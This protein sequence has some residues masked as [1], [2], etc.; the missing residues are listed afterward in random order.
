MEPPRF[1]YRERYERRRR[2]QTSS[3]RARVIA[4]LVGVALIGA[5]VFVLR[6]VFTPGDQPPASVSVPSQPTAT[7]GAPAD[8]AISTVGP[9]TAITSGQVPPKPPVA[10][11]TQATPVSHPSPSGYRRVEDITQW[12][13]LNKVR[14]SVSGS[15]VQ[16]LGPLGRAYAFV[17]NG[18]AP[19]SPQPAPSLLVSYDGPPDP[20][21]EPGVPL[22]VY[23]TAAGYA[24]VLGIRLP[25]LKADGVSRR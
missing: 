2:G 3:G 19:G 1:R 10:Q 7:P 5:G 15:F 24:D 16:G 20:Q 25:L 12:D 9:A 11:T 18:P 14:V 4:I 6:P 17:I 8:A 13:S 22:I 21:W 23:G